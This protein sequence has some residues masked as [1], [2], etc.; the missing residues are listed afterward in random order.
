MQ[1]TS[2]GGEYRRNGGEVSKRGRVVFLFKHGIE[3][4]KRGRAL[5]LCFMFFVQWP[6]VVVVGGVVCQLQL[7]L[8]YERSLTKVW[9][10]AKVWVAQK[11]NACHPPRK[12]CLIHEHP[13]VDGDGPNVP[14]PLELPK[15]LELE[16]HHLLFCL[17]CAGCSSRPTTLHSPNS[18]GVTICWLVETFEPKDYCQWD[19]EAS[20]VA[21]TR[22]AQAV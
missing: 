21:S 17:N 4:S 14:E 1:A 22:K 19:L 3:V 20:P 13:R 9:P 6:T 5:F 8:L 16:P 10:V 18:T 12:H 11:S 7:V 15:L 2:C